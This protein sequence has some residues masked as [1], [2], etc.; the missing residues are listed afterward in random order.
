MN[1]YYVCQN[2]T[3]KQESSGQY[4]WSPQ[5]TRNGSNNK[6]Y[7]NMAAVKKGD[8]IFHGAQQKTYA[9]SIAKADCKSKQQPSEL[10]AISKE[11][12]WDDKGYR[13]DSEY[14]MLSSA[15]NMRNL[16]EWFKEHYDQN[17]AFTVN[18]ECKQVYL[19]KLTSNHAKYIIMRALDLHQ[20]KEV[21]YTLKYILESILENEYAEYNDV[22]LGEIN[23][24]VDNKSLSTVKPSWK[25]QPGTQA[26]VGLAGPGNP[27][28]KRNPQIAANA[29][30]IADNVC[31]FDK[32]DRTFLR[33]S[34]IRYTEP[35][36]LIPISKYMDFEYATKKYRN[37]DVEENIV[38]LC[39]H[40]HNLL[41]YGRPEDKKSILK[42][43]FAKRQAVLRA[44]GL[45]LKTFEELMK[46]Y[47]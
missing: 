5:K 41:H 46:Y 13:V 44:V 34:G 11:S 8:V 6:G 27:K 42:K 18:G 3:F 26:F 38:S 33:K 23:N 12:I 16:F 19:N 36:H 40:C 22:E 10:K 43:L 17:S 29:L 37:L 9:I 14:T 25:G 30:T 4:L 1:I 28:P 20:D 32:S 47:E 35:H 39:S 31:E 2:K 21:N 45:E 15:V 24:I 7:I